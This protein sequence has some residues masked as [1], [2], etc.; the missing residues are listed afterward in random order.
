MAPSLLGF[1]FSISYTGGFSNHGAGT[2]LRSPEHTSLG[3]HHSP[4]VPHL[5]PLPQEGE[6]MEAE[7]WPV[8]FV[9]P[10]PA[11]RAVIGS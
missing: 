11:L 1:G 2:R 8:L 5:P 7:A 3:A 4:L 9:S 6:P 10:S